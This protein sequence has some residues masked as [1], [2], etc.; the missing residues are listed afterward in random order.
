MKQ[1][2]LIDSVPDLKDNLTTKE[3]RLMG[4]RVTDKVY[5]DDACVV[6]E[7]V[8]L[9]NK[10][11]GKVTALF[12]G[13][14]D[15]EHPHCKAQDL[16]ADETV[17][18][19]RENGHEDVFST[20]SII[21]EYLKEEEVD[22]ILTGSDVWGAMIAELLE[23]PS[24]TRVLDVDIQRGNAVLKMEGEEEWIKTSFPFLISTLPQVGEAESP[25]M[26]K[27]GK[28]VQTTGVKVD[29]CLKG[30]HSD[31]MDACGVSTS[32]GSHLTVRNILVVGEIQENQLEPLSYEAI[33]AAGK[34]VG[35]GEITAVLMGKE[36]H[37]FSN[38]MMAYGADG[39]LEIHHPLLENGTPDSYAQSL[40]KVLS[41][42]S[43][44]GVVFPDSPFGRVLAARVAVRMRSG[45]M[46]GVTDIKRQDEGIV[47]T[48][49]SHQRKRFGK[50][51]NHGPMGVFTITPGRFFP[52]IKE[53]RQGWKC[54]VEMEIEN[55]R[56]ERVDVK[57]LSHEYERAGV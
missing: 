30:E 23:I 46:T 45:L 29:H 47:F 6:E 40:Y 28:A 49:S 11:G 56:M 52:C 1:F 54:V 37:N 32:H 13:E 10:H 42:H 17:W 12:L 31:R 27:S 57:N 33:A 3:K 39:V 4:G 15:T 53:E 25:S 20:A 36:V 7:A 44:E 35:D 16:G 22:L 34:M 14:E 8:R 50:K 5:P 19:K 9:K 26:E 24:V 51:I 21:S 2:V 43:F 38:E 41:E 18:L 55:L 48:T